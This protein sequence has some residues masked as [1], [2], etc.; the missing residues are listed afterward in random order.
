MVNTR[1]FPKAPGRPGVRP[2]ESVR[3][4]LLAILRSG[5]SGTYLHVDEYDTAMAAGLPDL[6]LKPINEPSFDAACAAASSQST[7]ED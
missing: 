3:E 6:A 2:A 7:K 1:A 5:R 4:G